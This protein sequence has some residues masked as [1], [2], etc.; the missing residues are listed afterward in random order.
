MT[1]HY[2]FLSVAQEIVDRK[3]FVGSGMMNLNA[4][5]FSKSS[6]IWFEKTAVKGTKEAQHAGLLSCPA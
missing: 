2:S 3:G 1:R 6:S 4:Q 5:I